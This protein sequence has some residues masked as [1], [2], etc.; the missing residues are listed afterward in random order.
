[1][2]TLWPAKDPAETLVATFDYSLDLDA[3]E[4]IAT[5]AT[6]CTLL[7]GTDSNPSAV[8]SGSPTIDA[9]MVLQPFTGGVDGAV[10]TLRCQA[11]LT[12]TGRVLVLAATLPVRLA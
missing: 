12:P 2:R 7:A 1:M 5:A 8:L 11:T 9:G 3:G 6:T 4:T 10:Y